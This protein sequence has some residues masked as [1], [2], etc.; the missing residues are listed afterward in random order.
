MNRTCISIILVLSMP[1]CAADQAAD[2][3]SSDVG[4]AGV[5]SAIAG[6]AVTPNAPTHPSTT[7]PGPFAP[8]T[9]ALASPL[10]GNPAFLGAQLEAGM[11]PYFA[12]ADP[13]WELAR[14]GARSGPPAVETD[15]V[16]VGD[17]GFAERAVAT[18][19]VGV[20]GIVDSPPLEPAVVEPAKVGATDARSR[21]AVNDGIPITELQWPVDGYQ[22]SMVAKG[23]DAG[24]A[25]RLADSVE[26]IDSGDG[27]PAPTLAATDGFRA[28]GVAPEQVTSVS[29]VFVNDGDAL[30]VWCSDDG[31]TGQASYGTSARARTAATTFAGVELATRINQSGDPPHTALDGT[32]WLAS[33][34]WCQIWSTSVEED[35]DVS[36][37]PDEQVWHLLE[38]LVIVDEAQFAIASADATVKIELAPSAPAAANAG[39]VRF[40]PDGGR[41]MRLSPIGSAESVIQFLDIATHEVELSLPYA[42]ASCRLPISD[43]GRLFF[44][45]AAIRDT[46]TGD[47]VSTPVSARGIGQSADFSDD[48]TRIAISK[49]RELYTTIYDTATGNEL[50][51]IAI[52]G[53]VA[54]CPQFL[55]DDRHLFV[56]GLFPKSFVFDSETGDQ[57]LEIDVDDGGVTLS[58]DGRL[59]GSNGDR[60]LIVDL[61]DGTVLF[62]TPGVIS[63]FSADGSLATVHPGLDYSRLQVWDTAT[64][65]ELFE[66]GCTCLDY[67]FLALEDQIK[68]SFSPDGRHL[69]L[70]NSDSVAVILD[71]TNG[72]TIATLDPANGPHLSARYSPDG[73]KIVTLNSDGSIQ[74]WSATGD[75]LESE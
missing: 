13:S 58:P 70:L 38:S 30:E 75:R 51:T 31:E 54:I 25:S 74:L 6:S 14:F 18:I 19:T 37:V 23:L 50:L 26:F 47:V 11:V 43:D 41:L 71:A 57:L 49:G 66:T 53:Y 36:T 27:L 61:R 17:G 5:E 62:E 39:E 9:S 8:P 42:D 60:K 16:V 28:L 45:G 34:W 63:K 12:S 22:V 7:P 52:D 46:T 68:L 2:E 29:A 72:A 1:A 35:G 65:T 44:D 24:A 10:A 20:I 21:T 59:L 55:D 3:P 67:A 69:L 48:G 56:H 15:L 73:S 32:S 64:S 4:V 33:D 40:T